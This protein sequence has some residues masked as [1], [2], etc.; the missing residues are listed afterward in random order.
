MAAWLQRILQ[1]AIEAA[2]LPTIPVEIRPTGR[3]GGWSGDLSCTPDRRIC[4]TNQIVFWEQEKIIFYYLHEVGHR[5]LDGQN[6][7]THGPEF[8]CLNAV[9]LVRAGKFFA[10][11]VLKKIDLYDFQDQPDELADTP[12]WRGEVLNWALQI[13]AD[14]APTETPAEALA[15]IVCARWRQHLAEAEKSRQRATRTAARR[16][17]EIESLRSSLAL[18]TW[19]AGVGWGL[20]FLLCLFLFI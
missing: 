19:L 11:D 8:L 5:L 13:A 7:A 9:L 6:V 12:N 4:L 3:W 10:G 1:P 14:L 2:K 16:T 18:I 17:E 15:A 20:F